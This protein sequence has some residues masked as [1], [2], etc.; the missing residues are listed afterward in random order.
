MTL[1]ESL[2]STTPRIS[3][4]PLYISDRS[5]YFTSHDYSVIDVKLYICK[6]KFRQRSSEYTKEDLLMCN[7]SIISTKYDDEHQV[8]NI[9]SLHY[10]KKI[11]SYTEY[12]ALNDSIKICNSTDNFV[13][14]TWKLRNYG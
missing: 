6:V 10:K 3:N 1:G 5:Q 4:S 13:K 8:S 14:N 2:H 12:R 9:F 7:D 11:Y